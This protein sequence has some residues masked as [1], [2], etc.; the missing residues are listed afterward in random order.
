M[1]E[2]EK[3]LSAKLSPETLDHIETTDD[4]ARSLWEVTRHA[5]QH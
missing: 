1:M 4:Y 3:A 2:I 5:E